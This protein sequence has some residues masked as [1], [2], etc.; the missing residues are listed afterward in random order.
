MDITLLVVARPLQR[1][2][3]PKA[4]KA[5]DIIS[6]SALQEGRS[7]NPRCDFIHVMG[8]PDADI[9]R[10]RDLLIKRVSEPDTVE[11]DDDGEIGTVPGDFVHREWNIDESLIETNRLKAYRRKHELTMTWLELKVICSSREMLRNLS[12]SDV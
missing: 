12:D 2:D 4:P 3:K 1:A 6:V 10:Y 7:F 5:G 11:V 9:Q 8:I